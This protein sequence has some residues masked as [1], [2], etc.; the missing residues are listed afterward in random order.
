VRKLRKISIGL[1][2]ASIVISFLWYV[3]ADPQLGVVGFLLWVFL[4]LGLSSFSIFQI[5]DR[6]HAQF[7]TVVGYGILAILGSL[8]ILLFYNVGVTQTTSQL[9]S[10]ANV[11]VCSMMV[12]YGYKGVKAMI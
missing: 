5:I 6:S 1:I 7:H 12:Y 3:F 2:V 11:A 9:I 8:Y 4:F 10:I